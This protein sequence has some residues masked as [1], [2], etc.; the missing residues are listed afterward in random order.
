MH[1]HNQSNMKNLAIPAISTQ[2]PHEMALQNGQLGNRQQRRA[3]RILPPDSEP[4][5]EGSMGTLVRK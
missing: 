2:I 3:T 1:Q 4:Q 5:N